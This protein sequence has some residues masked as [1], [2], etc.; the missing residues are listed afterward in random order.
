[1][2]FDSKPGIIDIVLAIKPLK[3]KS[4]AQKYWSSELKKIPHFADYLRRDF[5]RQ[6][7]YRDDYRQIPDDRIADRTFAA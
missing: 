3:I 4:I 6:N 7:E 1:L 5:Y 2:Y